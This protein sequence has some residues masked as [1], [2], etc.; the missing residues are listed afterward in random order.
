M[1]KAE[2]SDERLAELVRISKQ[3]E[4][5]TTS[6][7]YAYRKEHGYE[8]V[9]GQGDSRARIMFIGEAPGEAEAKSGQPFCG[10][11]GRVLDELLASIGLPREGVYIT[12]IVKDRPPKN[13]DPLPA[14]IALYAPFLDR[15]IEVI[16]PKVIATLGRFSME[17]IMGRYGLKDKIQPIS[18][19]HGDTFTTAF[20]YGEVIIIPLYHPAVALYDPKQKAVLIKDFKKV[21]KA[22]KWISCPMDLN[23]EAFLLS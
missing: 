14:E 16:K 11:S 19:A 9:I 15:Q 23:P 22:G 1:G 21:K 18:K 7:L 17:Y 13:R 5:L 2:Q 4:G 20:A 6:L 3:I 12:N 8:P 10:R